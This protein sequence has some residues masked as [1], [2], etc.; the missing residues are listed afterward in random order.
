[1]SDG[2]KNGTGLSVS[3]IRDLFLPV[4]V[5]VT[6][7]VSPASLIGGTWELLEEGRT[8]V[9]ASDPDAETKKYPAGSVGG[10]EKHKLTEGELAKHKHPTQTFAY[11]P[12]SLNYAH[13]WGDE[14]W[15]MQDLTS[16]TMD[17][18]GDQPHNNMPPYISEYIWTRIA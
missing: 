10:E 9:A 8:I 4:G 3:Q 2:I 18:G 12:A 17:A 1:M 11:N 7:R 15:R 16:G 6:S 14:T 5:K 13:P